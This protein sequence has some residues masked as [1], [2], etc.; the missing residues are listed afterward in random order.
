MCSHLIW[1]QIEEE[2]HVF[3]GQV[4]TDFGPYSVYIAYSIL[5]YTKHIPFCT[6]SVLG[7]YQTSKSNMASYWFYENRMGC[8][9]YSD[10]YLHVRLSGSSLEVEVGISWELFLSITLGIPK[11]T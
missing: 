10:L 7:D 9:Y 5:R 6:C 11:V 4:S 3:D 2:S 1:Q 8:Y